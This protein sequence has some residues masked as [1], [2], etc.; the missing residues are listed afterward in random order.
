MS[1]LRVAV[2]AA[3]VGAVEAVGQRAQLELGEGS[4]I[5]DEGARSHRPFTRSVI[6]SY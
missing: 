1:L 2:A 4:N 3:D 5:E 6:L